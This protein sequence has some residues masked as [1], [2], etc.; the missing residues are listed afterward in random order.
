MQLVLAPAAQTRAPAAP[1]RWRTQ[2][3]QRQLRSGRGAGPRTAAPQG[4]PV[5]QEACLQQ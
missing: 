4:A 3:L 5:T 1:Q 2:Q